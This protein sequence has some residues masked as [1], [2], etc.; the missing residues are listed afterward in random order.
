MKVSFNNP[1][2]IV[3]ISDD[4]NAATTIKRKA[5]LNFLLYQ[6]R[7][8][9]LTISVQ[10]VP[11]SKNDDGTYGNR[12]DNKPTFKS[13][14]KTFTAKI[15]ENLVDVTTGLYLCDSKDEYSPG[16]DAKTGEPI[17]ILNPVLEGKDYAEE[18]DFYDNLANTTPV[19]IDDMIKNFVLY[20]DAQ[21][22]FNNA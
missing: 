12:L 22:R 11:Y 16:V 13:Y 8:K 14:E 5:E 4:I 9:M 3:D 6:P 19:V 2:L 1:L 21:G 10:V 15:G 17:Q 18:F 7:N 20:A